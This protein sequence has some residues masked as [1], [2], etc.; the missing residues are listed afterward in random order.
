MAH[1]NGFTLIEMLIVL[2][3]V[4]TLTILVIPR[5]DQLEKVKE[6]TYMIE[7]L[8]DDLL[9]AQQYA[10]THKTAVVVVFYNAQGRYRMTESY[11][12]GRTLIDRTLPS[13]WLFELA[14]LQN[15]LTFLANGNVNKSG[16][17]LIKNGK[18]TY[19]VVF[20]LGKGRF[21]VQKL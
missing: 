7:Q 13:Q 18:T 15:P 20:L 11:T 10:M 1:K 21:Y 9:Y 16:T 12:L 8:T 19:K 6:E 5:I 4:S 2:M 3:I 17:I 14:T